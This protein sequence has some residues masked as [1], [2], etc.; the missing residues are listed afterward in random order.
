MPP[1]PRAQAN[2]AGGGGARSNVE[3]EAL[4]RAAQVEDNYDDE[5]KKSLRWECRSLEEKIKGEEE[6][7]GLLVDERFRLNYFWLVAKKELEDKQAELRNKNRE[8][9]DLTEKDSITI[10]IWRQRLKHLMFQN[11]DQQTMVKLSAQ[12]R[13]KNAEDEHRINQREL[14]QDL[15]ALKVQ[16]KE[17]ETRQKDYQIALNKAYISKTSAIRK[18]AERISNEIQLKYKNKMALLRANMEKKRKVEIAKIE[19]KKNQDIEALK[20]KHAKKYADI[21]EYYSEI[22]RT[23]MDMITTLR[24][25]L[26]NQIGQQNKA[27]KDK[28]IQEAANNDIVKPYEAL[29][30]EIAH[31]EKEEQKCTEIK[32][33]LDECQK[34]IVSTESKYKNI[35]WEYEVKLQKFQYLENEKKQLFEEFHKVVYE[36]HQ[37][38]GLKNLLLEKKLE[39]IQEANETKDA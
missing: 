37:K 11:L 38:T 15:R 36:V 2:A 9:Q 28:A 3:A 7:T 32:R 1:R 16:Q 22:T 8:L 24:Q 12:V 5:Y 17:Q 20:N 4:A 29:Q 27:N 23:N 19:A 18:E 25:D 30:K 6:L 21:K 10:K 14:K 35:E 26:R 34:E 33:K 31:L 13:L 39:T